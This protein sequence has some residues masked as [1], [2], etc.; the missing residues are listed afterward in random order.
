[1]GNGVH[2]DTDIYPVGICIMT[3]RGISEMGHMKTLQAHHRDFVWGTL[4]RGR[5]ITFLNM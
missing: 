3:C 5:I 1:M 2:T 4:C